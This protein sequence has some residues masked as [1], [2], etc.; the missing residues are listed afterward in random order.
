V[1]SVE[2]SGVNLRPI[3]LCLV[4]CLLLWAG[5]GYVAAEALAYA[6]PSGLESE[7]YAALCPPRPAEY[8][9]T[10]ETVAQ[11]VTL[12]QQG[13]DACVRREQLAAQEHGD[14]G[15]VKASVE[16]VSKRLGESMPVEVQGEP[17]VKVAGGGTTASSRVE[18][19]GPE[20]TAE[21]DGNTEA[22]EVG[23]WVLAGVL[24]A[25][26]IF[27]VFRSEVRP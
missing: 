1:R 11:L 2:R 14:S 3:G 25:T 9:G 19:F 22:L 7:R 26:F 24:L 20:A 10:D 16:G 18:S 21:L 23:V 5:L 15:A 12:E 13:S 6:V 17:T 8:G 27:G 4:A